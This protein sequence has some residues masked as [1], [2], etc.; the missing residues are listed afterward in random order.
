MRLVAETGGQR[1]AIESVDV[2]SRWF[3]VMDKWANLDDTYLLTLR[4]FGQHNAWPAQAAMLKVDT[5]TDRPGRAPTLSTA[6]TT[7]ELTQ[8]V[9]LQSRQCPAR[10]RR[11]RVRSVESRC[12]CDTCRRQPRVMRHAVDGKALFCLVTF[13]GRS[14][15]VEAVTCC[16]TNS[17]LPGHA[18]RETVGCEAPGT[19]YP[20]D[21]RST[22]V[23]R[24]RHCEQRRGT[25]TRQ[26]PHAQLK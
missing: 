2:D 19:K 1:K 11:S 18:R 20:S 6:Q 12:R 17:C 7:R 3:H 8:A 24:N 25:G 5:S 15:E 13:S 4:G 23:T 26:V 14:L 16:T 22:L 21:G 9:R 10:I